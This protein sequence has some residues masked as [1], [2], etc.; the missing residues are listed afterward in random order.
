MFPSPS[1]MVLV[2]LKSLSASC[3]S[4][5][6]RS[7]ARL[8]CKQQNQEYSSLICFDAFFDHSCRRCRMK[9]TIAHQ[10]NSNDIESEDLG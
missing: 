6:P 5:V 8:V 1:K 3:F 2:L 4:V 9:R 7:W 10:K